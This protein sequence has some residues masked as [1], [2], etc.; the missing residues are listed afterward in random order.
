ML[1]S[2]P[3]KSALTQV[4]R[5][6]FA[7]LGAL[8]NERTRRRWAAVEAR[9]GD[10]FRV[11]RQQLPDGPAGNGATD[12]EYF[13]QAGQVPRRLELQSCAEMTSHTKQFILARR[14]SQ[15]LAPIIVA[16]LEQYL[17]RAVSVPV[18]A[19]DDGPPQS[20]DGGP[21]YASVVSC[22]KRCLSALV[23]ERL[24]S[25]TNLV[26]NLLGRFGPH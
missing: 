5:E 8:L 24:A 9:V 16:L 19:R 14:L 13:A 26:E 11:G 4:I 21:E 20:W 10:P 18:T 12:G 22:I 3:V 23:T 25:T 15:T 6:K 1:S 7:A 17:E 2:N